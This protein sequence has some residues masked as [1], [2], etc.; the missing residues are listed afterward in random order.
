VILDLPVAD[1]SSPAATLALRAHRDVA[2]TF[3]LRCKLIIR[4]AENSG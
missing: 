2:I 3:M 4:K 1:V